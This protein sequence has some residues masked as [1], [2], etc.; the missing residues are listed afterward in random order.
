MNDRL[1]LNL[2]PTCS[3]FVSFELTCENLYEAKE[4]DDDQSN[5]LGGCEQILDFGGRS[6]TDT[7]HKRQGG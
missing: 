3:V 1:L 6:H 2:W 4:D 7:V 5:Q